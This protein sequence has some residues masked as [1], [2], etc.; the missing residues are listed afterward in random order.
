MTVN[1]N[2]AANHKPGV[3]EDY[4]CLPLSLPFDRAKCLA[5]MLSKGPIMFLT[6]IRIRTLKRIT[7][8]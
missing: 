4:S 7:V 1:Q 5:E 6:E 3:S 2:K 8:H